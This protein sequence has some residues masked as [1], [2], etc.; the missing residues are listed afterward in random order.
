MM[1]TNLQV[2]FEVKRLRRSELETTETELRAMAVAAYM[3]FITI[4]NGARIPAATG[5]NP[6]L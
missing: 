5:I 2:S 1:F 6:V 4:P 3:G